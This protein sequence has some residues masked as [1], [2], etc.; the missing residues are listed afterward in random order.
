MTSVNLPGGGIAV[1]SKAPGANNAYIA[2]QG[3]PFQVEV[4]DPT[5][6]RARDLVTSG[7]I[8]PVG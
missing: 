2:E 1:Y 7:Q 3:V 8:V 4:F 5:P 6:G